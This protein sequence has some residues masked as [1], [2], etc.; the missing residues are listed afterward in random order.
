[1]G[2]FAN[3]LRANSHK[4]MQEVNHNCYAI[5]K[6][7]FVRAIH[8]TPSKFLGSQWAIGYLKNQWY[9]SNGLVFDTSLSSSADHRGSGSLLRVAKLGGAQFLWGDG[10]V[11]MT[12]N[13]KYA[14][15]A[16]MLGWPAG[17][18]GTRWT[19]T[20]GPYRMVYKAITETADFHK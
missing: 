11:T 10:A 16:E 12:N 20:V 5:A 7:C 8:Y 3:S 1:M 18:L 4:L 15:R 2:K 19:G 13:V 14:Y 9:V 6:E 17:V